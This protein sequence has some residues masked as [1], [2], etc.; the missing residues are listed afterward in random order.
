MVPNASDKLQM[1]SVAAIATW[2]ENEFVT[3][4]TWTAS[5]CRIE[6]RAAQNGTVDLSDADHLKIICASLRAIQSVRTSTLTGSSDARAISPLMRWMKA[7]LHYGVQQ[8]IQDYIAVMNDS[9]EPD[10]RLR[11]RGMLHNSLRCA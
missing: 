6:I 2:D 9:I 4:A 7:L 10:R 8:E 1:P 3:D 11:G 5:G